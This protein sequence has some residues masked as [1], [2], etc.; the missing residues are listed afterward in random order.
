MRLKMK[1]VALLFTTF[2][3]CL[4]AAVRASGKDFSLAGE[5]EIS[6][7]CTS[8][9]GRVRENSVKIISM[10]T[11]GPFETEPSTGLLFV[12]GLGLIG[13]AS[14]ISVKMKSAGSVEEGEDAG[15]TAILSSPTRSLYATRTQTVITASTKLKRRGA[16]EPLPIHQL[17]RLSNN[18]SS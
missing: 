13:A 16:T 17:Q 18:C 15:E 9:A 12:V 2:L 11:A 1:R 10:A 8:S 7:Y 14:L 4:P 5:R 6:S 3:L